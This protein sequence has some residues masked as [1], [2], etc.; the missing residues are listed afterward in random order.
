MTERWRVITSLPIPQA[1]QNCHGP[2]E[3]PPKCVNPNPDPDPDPNLDP[4]PNHK[5]NPKPNPWEAAGGDALRRKVYAGD[6]TIA[7][8]DDIG[9]FLGP[10]EVRGVALCN[11]NQLYKMDPETMAAWGNALRRT[12]P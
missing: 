4:D 2:L 12:P 9:L 3:A 6:G 8:R 5:P 10:S 7:T 11:F 1:Y